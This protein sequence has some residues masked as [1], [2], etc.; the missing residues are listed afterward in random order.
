MAYTPQF[1]KTNERGRPTERQNKPIFFDSFSLGTDA[2]NPTTN[3]TG[4]IA[5]IINGRCE[6]AS[7][8]DRRKGKVV[9]GTAGD[10]GRVYMQASLQV[11]D[12]N[13][14]FL[15][16][17]EG[18][19]AGVQL[20]KYDT[21][22]NSWKNLGTNIGTADDRVDWFATS[23]TI[24]DEDRV[25]F[26]NGVSDLMYTNGTTVTTVTGVKAKYIT[27][28]NNILVIGH[29]TETFGANNVI[30]ADANTHR[31]FG[32]TDG[33]YASS[34]QVFYL[35][36][37]ITQII[38]LNSLLY[39][40]TK[41]DG[42]WEIDLKDDS[43]RQISTHG[44]MSPKSVDIDWDVM[45]WVDQ[46]GVWALPIGGDVLKISLT[47]DNIFSQVTLDNI[48]QIVGGFNTNGQYEL[49]LGTLTYEG[50]QYPKYCLV[51][52]A[53]Q[54]RE[55]GQNT[56]KEDEGKE[57]PN[58]ICKWT[59]AYGFTQ[60][61]Y[62]SRTNQTTY[63]DDYGYEDG[64]GVKIEMIMETADVQV[65]REKEEGFLE[66]IY[67]TYRP[68]GTETIPLSVY[69]R[70]DTETWILQKS[71]SL[72]AGSAS[73]KTV[74]IQASKAMKGRKFAFK[75]VSKDN[76]SFRI[77]DIFITYGITNSDIQPI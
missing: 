47:I 7:T 1:I 60:T 67:I 9:M 4:N 39:V 73:M 29:A 41:S 50:V 44:T 70:N 35:P 11:S 14:I 59:N 22:D 56:W 40:F 6:R 65:A 66:D 55:L 10:A 54:S 46:D 33:G 20:Q 13:D 16:I 49:H 30:Y 63:L 17:V 15:R 34:Q 37:E 53:E 31:F 75:I 19:G 52:E 26:T 24:A 64:A 12:G 45:I 38:S 62:G 18:S 72:P 71:V 36:G 58:N 57:F 69:A 77:Y 8:L 43:I 51:Y 23:V 68:N 3:S 61:Y 76:K 28:I 2:H 25:Y 48:Y 74:R 42:L 32:A 21:S 27:H 5:R